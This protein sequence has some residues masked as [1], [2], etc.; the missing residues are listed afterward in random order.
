MKHVIGRFGESDTLAQ[1]PQFLYEAGYGSK[2]FP[3]RAGQIGVTQPRRVAAIAAARRVAEELNCT[4]G[5]AVGYQASALALSLLSLDCPKFK[6][7]LSISESAHYF[8]GRRWSCLV[9]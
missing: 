6:S 2:R 5:G 1:V 4:V 7:Y 3:E 9:L 8:A